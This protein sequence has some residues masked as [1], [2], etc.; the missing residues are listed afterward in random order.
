MEIKNK[1]FRNNLKSKEVT[2]LVTLIEGVEIILK[3]M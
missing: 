1:I 2:S 3:G